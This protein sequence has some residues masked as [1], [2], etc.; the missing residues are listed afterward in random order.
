MNTTRTIAAVA[1]STLLATISFHA[2]AEEGTAAA[3]I[4]P[5]SHIELFNGKDFTGWVFFMKTNADPKLTWSLSNGVV[6]C[7]GKP[8]GYM[9]TDKTYRDYRLT[10]E[11][12]FLKAGNTGVLVHM[13]EP[14]KVWPKCIECQGMS[15]N[16]GDFIAV[17]GTT[18]KELTAEGKGRVPKRGE[19]NE[20]PIGEWNTYQIVCSGDTIKPS[21][22]GKLMNEATGCSVTSGYILLQSEGTDIEIRKV[23]LDPL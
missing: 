23:S 6:K 7:T 12:R 4:K 22:N 5:T 18:F 3:P 13:S 9:R 20:K 10:V 15:G 2:F 1:A 19:S 8:A 21:V 16:Q 14:D 11:W 17:G